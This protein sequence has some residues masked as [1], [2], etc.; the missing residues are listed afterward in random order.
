MLIF[1]RLFLDFRVSF[2]GLYISLRLIRFVNGI[3]VVEDLG[4]EGGLFRGYFG[5]FRVSLF[6]RVFRLLG[7]LRKLILYVFYLFFLYFVCFR[8][9]FVL[10]N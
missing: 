1:L 5:G 6:F 2:V 3:I 4:F 7:I 9:L 10:E 8:L